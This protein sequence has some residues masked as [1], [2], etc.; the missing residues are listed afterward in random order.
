M[1]HQMMQRR[2]TVKVK[3]SWLG[4]A[5]FVLCLIS[6]V[7]SS[8]AQDGVAE[9][10]KVA[11]SYMT[12]LFNGDV[13]TAA[14]L[15]HSKTLED[16]RNKYLK[17]LDKAKAEGREREFLEET[18]VEADAGE[19]R[20]MSSRELYVALMKGSRQMAGEQG[21]AGRGAEVKVESSKKVGANEVSVAL[22]VI[23]STEKGP[24]PKTGSLLLSKEG[25][26]WRVKASKK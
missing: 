16:L 23:V 15:T 5:V 25:R 17:D 11:V 8:Q 7:A 12:A 3:R 18:G 19:I 4:V 9:A 2:Q 13:E 24:V 10:K 26:D 1:V 6:F 14:K 22:K 21:K 20:A